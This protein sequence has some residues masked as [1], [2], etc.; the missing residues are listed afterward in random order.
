MKK[1]ELTGP[2][3]ERFL[4]W[5]DADRERAGEKHEKIRRRLVVFFDGRRCADSESLADRAINR[6]IRYVAEKGDSYT[7]ERTPIFYQAAHY[8]Y[9]EYLEERTKA[10]MSLPENVADLPLPAPR[11]DEEDE[12]RHRCL[13][14]CLRKLPAEKQELI[15]AYY[16]EDKQAKIDWR[17]TLAD[18][19]GL[20]ANALRLQ[21]HRLRADL[22]DCI[23]ECLGECLDEAAPGSPGFQTV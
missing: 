2:D 10:P 18:R 3:Y 1:W 9:L 15:V 4:N 16:R 21:V 17:K 12:A 5:L 23:H 20:S 14:T 22:E 7:G 11:S 8:V 19:L 6:I 13:E